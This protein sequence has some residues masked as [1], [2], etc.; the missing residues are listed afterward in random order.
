M[1]ILS[2]E[3]VTGLGRPKG[4]S[5]PGVYLVCLFCVSA[6]FHFHKLVIFH[7]FTQDF[8]RVRMKT[9]VWHSQGV[10]NSIF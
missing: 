4:S 1:C 8:V 2:G 3:G 9:Q 7:I 5:S 10:N 6:R